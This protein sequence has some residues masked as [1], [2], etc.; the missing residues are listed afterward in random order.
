MAAG[1]PD[2]GADGLEAII[3]DA[4]DEPDG[5]VGFGGTVVADFGGLDVA[6]GVDAFGAGGAGFAGG[7]DGTSDGIEEVGGASGATESLA[8]GDDGDGVVAVVDGVAGTDVAADGAGAGAAVDAGLGAD[9]V[10]GAG[11]AGAAGAG[12]TG[13]A[14]AAAGID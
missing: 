12:V 7:C 3:E 14:D 11:D 5:V 4:D 13:A 10:G 6:G 9:C 8:A 2:A 1:V